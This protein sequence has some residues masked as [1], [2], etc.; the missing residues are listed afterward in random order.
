MNKT[1]LLSDTRN[2]LYC[3]GKNHSPSKNTI[4][5]YF[6]GEFKESYQILSK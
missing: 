2:L 3:K 4:Y 1:Q 5:I 6:T